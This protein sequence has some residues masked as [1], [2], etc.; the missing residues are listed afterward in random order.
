ML[1]EKALELAQSLPNSSIQPNFSGMW[2]N[3]MGSMM[4]VTVS[5]DDV[6]GTYTSASSAAGG[7]I[8]GPLKGFVAGD[9]ISF[10]VLWPGGSQTA[11]VGQMVG[12][13]EDP[14]IRTL[15]HLVTN[16]AEANEPSELWTST[17]A[18]ADEFTR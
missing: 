4:D 7:P 3:Q 9:L 17:Y 18:G 1:H 12:S 11:W 13:D 6:F 10:L 15:W 16:V 8:A 5:G 14:A 2:R